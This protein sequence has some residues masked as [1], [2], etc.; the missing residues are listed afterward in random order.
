VFRS[1]ARILTQ[2][3]YVGCSGS[4]YTSIPVFGC[5]EKDV[6]K[7]RTSLTLSSLLLQERPAKRSLL[8]RMT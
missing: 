6:N 2:L 7:R 5:P 1:A 4:A 8:S 3:V